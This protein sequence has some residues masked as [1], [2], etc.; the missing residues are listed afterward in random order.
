MR[1]KPQVGKLESLDDVNLA[2]RDI[3]LK[4]KELDAI[5]SKAAKEIAE[6]KTKAAKDGEE[7]RKEIAETAGKIQAFAEYNKAELFKDKKSVDLSFGKIGYRQSTKIS[8]K[9]TTLELLKKLGFKSCVRIKEECDKDAMGNLSDDDLKSVDAARKVS[10]D[11][12]CEANME[13]V[14]KDLLKQ[15]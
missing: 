15:A 10:N 7:L 9:K 3:G 6:I 2:L 13:E 12:F 14:N 1:I 5:D 11:F 4:E 8:V